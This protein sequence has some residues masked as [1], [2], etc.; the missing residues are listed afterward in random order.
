MST[1]HMCTS[2]IYG[3]YVSYIGPPRNVVHIH[4]LTLGKN[5]D[6]YVEI[7]ATCQPEPIM[8]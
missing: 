8:C 1:Y 4:I 5:M 3:W 2:V 6:L 7:P